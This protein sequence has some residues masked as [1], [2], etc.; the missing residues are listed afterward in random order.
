MHPVAALARGL[1]TL[2]R[3]G[4]LR[5]IRFQRLRGGAQHGCV[6]RRAG[7]VLWQ[8]TIQRGQFGFAGQRLVRLAWIVWWQWRGHSDSTSRRRV[9]A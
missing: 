9:M 8:L 6:Q 2:D 7:F 4:A 1:A 5:S 3:D